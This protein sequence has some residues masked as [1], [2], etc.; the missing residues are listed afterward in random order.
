MLALR[1]VSFGI[2]KTAGTRDSH[3]ELKMAEAA[4]GL[5]GE[6]QMTGYQVQSVVVLDIFHEVVHPLAGVCATGPQVEDELKSMGRRKGH[7]SVGTSGNQINEY[8]LHVTER[9]AVSLYDT[10]T[11]Q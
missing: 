5:I 8:L 7:V 1:S 6:V 3:L 2:G 4:V 9:A 10:V 11:V